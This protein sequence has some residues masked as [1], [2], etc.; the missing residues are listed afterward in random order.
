MSFYI[1][2]IR[3]GVLIKQLLLILLFGK[4]AML[5]SSIF[6]RTLNIFFPAFRERRLRKLDTAGYLACLDDVSSSAVHSFHSQ[7]RLSLAGMTGTL[8]CKII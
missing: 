1:D 8:F 2:Y 3:I 7:A 6:R 4:V 5:I